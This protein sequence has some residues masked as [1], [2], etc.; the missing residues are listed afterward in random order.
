M[1]IPARINLLL[2]IPGEK[3]E[4]LSLRHK[5][6]LTNCITMIAVKQAVVACKYRVSFH[7]NTCP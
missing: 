5:K 6:T 2:V 3:T 1:A 7:I 4:P